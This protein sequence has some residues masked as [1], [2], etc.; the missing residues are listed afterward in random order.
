MDR[1]A[2]RLRRRDGG[3]GTAPTWPGS[4]EWPEEGTGGRLGAASQPR[5]EA[6]GL[7][8]RSGPAG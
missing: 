4:P 6:R 2:P 3:G 8:R 1:G 5:G 7:A